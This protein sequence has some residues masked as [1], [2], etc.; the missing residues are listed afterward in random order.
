MYGL[1]AQQ[2]NKTKL[3]IE[4]FHHVL[5]TKK[6]AQNLAGTNTRSKVLLKAFRPET[7][8]PKPH[9]PEIHAAVSAVQG[10]HSHGYRPLSG[11]EEKRAAGHRAGRFRV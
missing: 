3:G 10:V 2:L 8:I 1:T 9:E 4:S 7:L 5:S 6:N 11:E